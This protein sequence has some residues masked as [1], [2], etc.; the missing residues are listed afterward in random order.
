MSYDWFAKSKVDPHAFVLHTY[1]SSKLKFVCVTA[2]SSNSW[3]IKHSVFVPLSFLLH[4]DCMFIE[5]HT[6]TFSF[7]FKVKFL[8]CEIWI[9]VWKI[10]ANYSWTN[11]DYD[12]SFYLLL[13]K[14]RYQ[15]I[16]MWT[17]PYG[18]NERDSQ[19]PIF[20]ASP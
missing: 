5:Q 10:C 11:F 16:K 1:K 14:I 13:W 7:K 8:S 3:L 4:I 20:S 15:F 9:Y 17:N 6:F 19:S 18:R 12:Y 2:R